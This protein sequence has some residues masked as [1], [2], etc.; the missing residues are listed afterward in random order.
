MLIDAFRLTLKAC[1]IR[2]VTLAREVGLSTN[3][4]SAILRGAQVPKLNTFEAM[5]DACDRIHPGFRGKFFQA[6]AQQQADFSPT[7]LASLSQQE[8]ANI[9]HSVVA[10]LRSRPNFMA[11]DEKIELVS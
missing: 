3:S 11:K 4:I 1:G 5:L 10:E 9:L 7:S 2:G 8:L 6:L